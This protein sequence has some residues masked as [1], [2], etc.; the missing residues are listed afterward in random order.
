MIVEK[1]AIS[2]QV[3]Q[4]RCCVLNTRSISPR[5]LNNLSSLPLDTNSHLEVRA[6]SARIYYHTRLHH[7]HRDLWECI[8]RIPYV[9]LLRGSQPSHKWFPLRSRRRTLDRQ[10]TSMLVEHPSLR[11]SET[12]EKSVIADSA[13]VADVRVVKRVKL[14]I[15]PSGVPSEGSLQR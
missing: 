7:D 12:S 5:P 6:Y 11:G 10:A 8:S 1:E 13:A 14:D 9:I 15:D 4:Q 3:T 2:T